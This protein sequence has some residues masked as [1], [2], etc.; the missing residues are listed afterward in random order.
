MKPMST[1]KDTASAG[2]PTTAAEVVAAIDAGYDGEAAKTP[3]DYVGASIVGNPCD[4]LLAFSLRGFPEVPPP[5]RLKR[6]FLLGHRLEDQVVK[7]LKQKADVRVWEVDGLTGRQFA[8]EAWGGHISSHA[9]GH[10]EIGEEMMLLEVKSM[11][12][13]SFAKFKDKGVKRS[14]PQYFAQVQM[15]MGMSGLERSFFIAYCKDN[16]E[17]HAEI[18]DRDELEIA[19]IESRV[20]RV[21]RGDIRKISEDETDWRCRGCFKRGVCWH[22]QEVPKTCQ[23]CAHARPRCDGGW[24]CRKHSKPAEQACGDW[25]RFEPKPKL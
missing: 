25:E 3:R 5:A 22:G 20:E 17:Y 18:V 15:M 2:G 23:T 11:N 7:D 24:W 8:Y 19:F 6:V 1:K 14:H 10:I 9:D 4:A 21:L 12:A 16:S 13:A